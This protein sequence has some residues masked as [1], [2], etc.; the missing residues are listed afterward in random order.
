MFRAL[1][2]HPQ[3]ALQTAFGILRAYNV[4]WLR[5]TGQEACGLRPG[6]NG[7]RNSVIAVGFVGDLPAQK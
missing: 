1:L 6:N 2:P 5:H 3:E 4:S 7:S